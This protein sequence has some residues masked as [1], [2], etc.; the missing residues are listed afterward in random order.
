MNKRKL[1]EL[2]SDKE[3]LL[4]ALEHSILYLSSKVPVCCVS[5]I[6]GVSSQDAGGSCGFLLINHSSH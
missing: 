3:E 2:Q 1:L 4:P 6:F 5:T